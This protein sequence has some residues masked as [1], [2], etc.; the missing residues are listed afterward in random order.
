[1]HGSRHIKKLFSNI[2]SFPNY[3]NMYYIFCYLFIQIFLEK[4]DFWHFFG[5][6]GP[7]TRQQDFQGANIGCLQIE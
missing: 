2:I 3:W 5:R 6:F 7:T 1:M 4:V